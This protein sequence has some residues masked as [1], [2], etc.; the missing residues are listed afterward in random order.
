MS[1][2]NERCRFAVLV[3]T[4][5][6]MHQHQQIYAAQAT[7]MRPKSVLALR[8]ERSCCF[9]KHKLGDITTNGTS[10]IVFDH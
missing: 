1:A 9:S 2:S 10:I 5:H 8:P 7:S 4:F 3:T 6:L